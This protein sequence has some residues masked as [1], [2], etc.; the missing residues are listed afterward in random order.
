M[1]YSLPTNRTPIVLD[2]N[3][4]IYVEDPGMEVAAG[5]LMRLTLKSTASVV[6]IAKKPDFYGYVNVM[7]SD[8]SF[9]VYVTAKA[10]FNDMPYPYFRE[11]KGES[12]NAMKE[13]MEEAG[14]GRDL[15]Y[16]KGRSKDRPYLMPPDVAQTFCQLEDRG[17]KKDRVLIESL[18]C[19]LLTDSLSERMRQTVYFYEAPFKP[20]T[21]KCLDALKKADEAG[22]S[23]IGM[24]KDAPAQANSGRYAISAKDRVIYIRDRRKKRTYKTDLC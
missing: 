1:I 16:I 18:L 10:L 7:A 2:T 6:A 21:V 20:Y 19:A 15:I 3:E 8:L 22:V 17:S 23:L 14:Q 11:L 4:G 12:L 5:Y 13:V 9:V 24:Y